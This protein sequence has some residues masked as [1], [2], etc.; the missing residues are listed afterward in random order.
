LLICGLCSRVRRRSTGFTSAV[1][2]SSGMIGPPGFRDV[3]IDHRPR[4]PALI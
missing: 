3:E 1:F 2:V 4:Y